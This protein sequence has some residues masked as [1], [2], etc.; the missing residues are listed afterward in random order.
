MST[1]RQP[2][3]SDHNTQA[4]EPPAPARETRCVTHAPAD[5]D[6]FTRWL[7]SCS[8]DDEPLSREE[9]AALAESED[10]IAEGRT[11]SFEVV[12]AINRAA[13]DLPPDHAFTDAAAASLAADDQR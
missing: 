3:V 5:R 9:R 6:D 4:V 7:N 13:A 8:E 10:D 2:H 1:P 11:V 12:K